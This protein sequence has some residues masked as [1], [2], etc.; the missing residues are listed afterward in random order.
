MSER[1]LVPIGRPRAPGWLDG[2]LPQPLRSLLREVN[3]R[4]GRLP[5]RTNEYGYDPF[6]FDP[7]YARYTTFVSSLIYRFYFRVDAR[8]IENVPEGR[9]LL[10]AN[11]AGNTIA[12]DGAML[13]TS[14]FLD[15]EPPRMV[16]GMAEYYLPTIPTGT[17]GVS[18]SRARRR[19]P[20][21]KR[22]SS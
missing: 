20:R 10:I 14:L 16:R 11:H 9:V 19:K 8:G 15:G 6:G 4:I 2:W 17:I 22:C 13:A 7:E 1:A 5:T 3:A 12:W 18:V 21:P